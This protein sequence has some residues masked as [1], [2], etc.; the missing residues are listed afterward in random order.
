[1]K[2]IQ[3]FWSLL[4]VAVVT[5]CGGGNGVT[6]TVGGSISGLTGTVVLESG[7]VSKSFSTNGTQTLTN[8]IPDGTVYALSVKTQPAGQ[9]CT[10]TNGSGTV[11]ANVTNV[12]VTCAAMTRNYTTVSTLVSP[13]SSALTYAE[14]IA[15]DVAGNLYVADMLAHV[16][17]KVTPAGVVTTFAGSGVAGSADGSGTAASFNYPN[18]V[19]VDGSGNVYVADSGNN[20]IRKISPAGAVTTLAGS[21]AQGSADGTGSSARF[22]G[23]S[24][25]TVD[26]SGNVYVSDGTNNMIRKITPAGVVT[27]VA[28]STSSG[29]ADGTG[30][31]ATFSFPRGIVMD[32]SG[33]L[34]V[35]DSWN[36]TV[37][38]ISPAGV[39]T[40][41]AG[42]TTAGSA[43][44][45]G[46]AAS[47]TGPHGLALD[48]SGNVYVADSDTIRKITPL[49][50]VTTLSGSTSPSAS[51]TDGPV[52]SATYHYLQGI[53]I[54]SNGVLYA[55]ESYAVRKIE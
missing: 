17:R 1:M 27:T 3:G 50:E 35:A 41:L 19:A 29:H 25:L 34:L 51:G 12:V 21:T 49:G 36:T 11:H 15:A 6:Y 54:D 31:S 9:I 5:A 23:P 32:A 8:P 7:G 53:T 52:A 14:G 2:P 28:G 43:D 40:T 20:M 39:V 33:N 38:K 10:V 46:T 22:W 13:A 30:T 42:S 44:G 47:F 26:A 16:I 48:A 37:R 55:V 4:L 24:G 18:A 45:T